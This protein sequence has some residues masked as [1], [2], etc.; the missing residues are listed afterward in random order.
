[1]KKHAYLIKAHHQFG[2]LKKLLQLL[3]D[4][5]N[6][7]YIHIAENISFDKEEIESVVKS[8]KLVWTNP[9]TESWGGY[10]QIVSEL[11]LFEAAYKE[12]YQYYHLLSGVDLPLKTQDEI[13]KFF[14][15]NDGKEF[16]Y[17]CG[18]DFWKES[19]FKHE[20]YHLFQEKVGREKEGI[21]YFLERCILFLQRKVGI[22]RK[23]GDVEFCLGANWCSI[24]HELVGF[25]L[26]NRPQ[27]KKMFRYTLCCDEFYK[28]TLIWNSDYIKKVYSME[29]DYFACLRL[30]D[31]KRGKPYVW[32]KENLEELKSAPHLFARKF[33]EV[34][35][36]EV[37]EEVFVYIL[38]QQKK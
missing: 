8:S 10:S 21:W 9:T 33:D 1:M 26:E 14:D 19:K 29:D 22:C 30:I 28:H 31:W 20:Q 13:H 4:E 23:Y 25:L 15:E 37:I 36:N 7:I 17:F 2:L 35:D 3:D 34:I 27:I 5:R 16:L 6:D 24:T 38:E 12:G 32:R 18:K 11:D